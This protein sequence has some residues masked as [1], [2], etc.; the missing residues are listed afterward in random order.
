MLWSLLPGALLPVPWN[1][2]PGFLDRF[3]AQML[4]PNGKVRPRQLDSLSAVLMDP[5]AALPTLS[6]RARRPA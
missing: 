1:D 4:R 5:V 6:G 2:L 3:V